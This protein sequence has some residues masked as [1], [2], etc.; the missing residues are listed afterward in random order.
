ML[1]L[2]TRHLK[3]PLLLFGEY[4]LLFIWNAYYH[5]TSYCQNNLIIWT[6]SPHSISWQG[7]HT[8]GYFLILLWVFFPFLTGKH[9][10]WLLKLNVFQQHFFFPVIP[11][12][13][14]WVFSSGRAVYIHVLNVLCVQLNRINSLLSLFGKSLVCCASLQVLID[15]YAGNANSWPGKSFCRVFT[16]FRCIWPEYNT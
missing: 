10:S 7:F 8:T 13:Y 12:F 6:S 15:I 3:L 14:F 2:A 16:K 4:F 9:W 11:G 1:I 5:N